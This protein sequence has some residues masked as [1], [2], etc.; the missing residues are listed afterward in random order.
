MFWAR[1]MLVIIW[2]EIRKVVSLE[3]MGLYDIPC[4][5]INILDTDIAK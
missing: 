5:E 3:K 4:V 1:N 2:D